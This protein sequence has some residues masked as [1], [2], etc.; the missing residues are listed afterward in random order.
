[1]LLEKLGMIRIVQI[2]FAWC[3]CCCKVL[4]HIAFK[5][6]GLLC[7]AVF[8]DKRICCSISECGLC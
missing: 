7:G 5:G 8:V 4:D 1:M 2:H 3:W 6:A